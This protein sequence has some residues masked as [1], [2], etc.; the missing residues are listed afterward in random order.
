[1]LRQ[2]AS[3]PASLLRRRPQFI[4]APV[5]AF[6]RRAKNSQLILHTPEQ[7]ENMIT[8]RSS[9]QELKE[10]KRAWTTDLKDEVRKFRVSLVGLP[11]CG[12]SSL[13]NCLVGERIAIVD[14]HR[15]T[16]RDR[17]EFSILEG[18]ASVIDTPGV[19][20]D[21]IGRS[22]TN[23]LK[24][25]IFK[26]TI[27]AIHES[28]LIL[29]VVDGKKPTTVEEMEFAKYLKTFGSHADIA[30]VCNKCDNLFDEGDVIN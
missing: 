24:E 6:S 29:F 20:T 18:V 7:I 22:T 10:E 19:E 12:K 1:M 26:Q 13:F 9:K 4:R 30:L 17:K 21:L 8:R 16:T 28:H 11:N 23:K 25:E 2:L 14:K 3:L 27:T 5:F 15:G